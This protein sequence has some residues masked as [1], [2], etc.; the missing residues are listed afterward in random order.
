MTLDPILLIGG[1]GAIGTST[2]RTLRADHPDVPLLI[3]GR[4][5]A[6]AARAAAEIG[7]AEGVVLNLAATDLGVGQRPVSAVAVFLRDDKATSLRFAQS[8][9]VPHFGIASGLQE[10]GPEV[11]AF[12]HRP[13]AAPVV[14]G[15]EWLVGATTVPTLEFAKA[16]SEVHDITLGA[17]VDEQEVI[18]SA[19]TA[20]IEHLSTTFPAALARRDGA[21]SWLVG[22][23]ATAEFHAVDGTAVKAAAF[24][25]IDIVSLATVTGAANVQFNLASGISSTRRRGG[26]LSTE[27]VVEIAGMDHE[28]RRLRTR[29]AVV[30]DGTVRLTGL[31]VAMVLERLLGLD[32]NPAAPAGLYFPYQL[33]ENTAYLRRLKETGGALNELEVL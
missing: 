31:G 22:D 6:K 33:L 9:G 3:G 4:D 12:M 25:S 14:L 24:S 11:A 30:H 2:A 10:I 23:D 28:G 8:R 1:Y 27:I 20:D 13:N 29:H 15:A 26:P 32:G 17:L 7:N 5:R 19:S 16:F 18:G 21:Y